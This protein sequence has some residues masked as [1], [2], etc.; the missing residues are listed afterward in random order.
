MDLTQ[1]EEFFL[2]AAELQPADRAEFLAQLQASDPAAGYT[3]QSL[4]DHHATECDLCMDT[5]ALPRQITDRL[6]SDPGLLLPGARIDDYRIQRLLGSGGMG[7]VFLAREEEPIQRDVA[8]KVLKLEAHNGSVLKRFAVE[9]Q[10][11]A[12]LRHPGIPRIHNAGKSENGRSWLAMEY[13]PGTAI[14][15]FCAQESL[16]LRQR[17]ELFIRLCKTVSYIHSQGIIHRDIKPSNVL[18]SNSQG[19][20]IPYLVD[21]GIASVISEQSEF[22]PQTDE[23]TALGTM[24]YMC[25]EQFRPQSGLVT[26]GA[27]IW[28]LGA[29]LYELLTGAAPFTECSRHTPLDRLKAMK[30]PPELPSAKLLV[31]ADNLATKALDNITR[32]CLQWNTEDRP[33]SVAELSERLNKLLNNKQTVVNHFRPRASYRKGL[34]FAIACLTALL[35]MLLPGETNAPA[36]STPAV[37]TARQPETTPPAEEPATTEYFSVNAQACAEIAEILRRHG[38]SSKHNDIKV[39]L[40]PEPK[41]ESAAG[42]TVVQ[43]DSMSDGSIASHIPVL[44]DNPG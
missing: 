41:S 9:R 38:L 43:S 26:P 5:P 44:N 27:D 36:V 18:V 1:I 12:V 23:A 30:T 3:V 17:I 14:T 24:D 6:I 28:S 21:F 31:P 4:L 33:Q 15:Q 29:L 2:T 19:L 10:V 13:V 42:V 22:L 11:L 40:T 34:G 39:V 8:L 7:D 25:P 37:V 35:L 32:S 16:P 20:A